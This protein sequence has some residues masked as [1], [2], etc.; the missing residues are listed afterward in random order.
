MLR[1]RVGVGLSTLIAMLKLNTEKALIFHKHQNEGD[2]CGV[3][4]M[5]VK[6]LH[7]LP[8]FYE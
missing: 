1:R 4:D 6:M 5:Q 2:E 7:S 8:S 3:V